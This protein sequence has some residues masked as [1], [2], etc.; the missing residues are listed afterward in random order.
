M[1]VQGF[2]VDGG[3]C[4]KLTTCGLGAWGVITNKRIAAGNFFLG[5]FDLSTALTETLLS[6]RFGIPVN[7]KPIR[8]T[9]WYMYSPGEEMMDC[10]GNLLDEDD[11]G[12]IYC[13]L[14]RNHDADGNYVV[15]T[16]EDT[17]SSEL[18]VGRGEWNCPPVSQWTYFEVDIDYWDEVDEDLLASMGYNMALVCSSSQRGAY[19][20]GA[21]NSTLYI[22]NLSI[23]IEKTDA[24]EADDTD[25]SSEP[26]TETE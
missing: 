8:L 22:D 23:I 5:S 25:T 2:G 26:E 21:V 14:Y 16:G 4:V 1:P 18:R 3:S 10:Y 7:Y 9:G 17:A 6:T 24:E 19:Y 12:I 13:Q 20:E 15:L 11:T